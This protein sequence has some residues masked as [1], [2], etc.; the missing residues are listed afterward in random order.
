MSGIPPRAAQSGEG[1]KVPD[2]AKA[3]MRLAGLDGNRPPPEAGLFFARPW[4]EQLCGCHSGS[5]SYSLCAA[6]SIRGTHQ[7]RF[8]SHENLL[9][10]V[11]IPV[12]GFVQSQHMAA[13]MT[14]PKRGSKLRRGICVWRMAGRLER[15]A[16]KPR[17]PATAQSLKP[18]SRWAKS[19]VGLPAAAH[20][21]LR[22]SPPRLRL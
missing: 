10:L 1:A 4:R 22:S 19:S 3:D 5:L 2:G 13:V 16:P 8:P 15:F 7:S 18:N 20:T 12:R 9:P 17:P 14:K 6:L 21:S 11:L